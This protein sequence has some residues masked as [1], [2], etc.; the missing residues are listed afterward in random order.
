MVICEMC[1]YRLQF[2]IAILAITQEGTHNAR[3]PSSEK[4]TG[5]PVIT[6]AIK[7]AARAQTLGH[8]LGAEQ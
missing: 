5:V 2:Q 3:R 4:L 8:I 7:H 6:H 1:T